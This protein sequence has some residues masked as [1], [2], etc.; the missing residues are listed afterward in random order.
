MGFIKE[1]KEFAIKGNVIDLAV[2]VVLAAAFGAII[3][4][5]T[6]S[7]I[8]PLVSIVM[9]KE[10]VENLSYAVGETIFPYGLFLKALINFVLV[11]LVL[12]M[13]IRT[14][15]SLKRKKEVQADAPAEPEYTLSEKLLMEIR[16][17]IRR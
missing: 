10:G 3:T 11:A 4:A 1:F 14:M 15:N 8:M 7:F 16:D 5:L 13:V 17:N 6:E 12:F 2:A 9:G